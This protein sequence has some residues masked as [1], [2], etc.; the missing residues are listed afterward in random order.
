LPLDLVGDVLPVAVE[1]VLF[2]GLEPA[3]GR[4]DQIVRA[5]LA[6]QMEVLLAD[7]AAV[8]NPEAA[9]LWPVQAN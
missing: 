1:E 3:L 5:A 4:A 7:D 6:E 2:A 8:K 9:R